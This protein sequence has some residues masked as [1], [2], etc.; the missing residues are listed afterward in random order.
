MDF[1]GLSPPADGRYCGAR[2]KRPSP[3]TGHRLPRSPRPRLRR[4]PLPGPI[5]RWL[6]L[7]AQRSHGTVGRLRGEIEYVFNIRISR[8]GLQGLIQSLKGGPASEPSSLP[9]EAPPSRVFPVRKPAPQGSGESPVQSWGDSPVQEAPDS[10]LEP[11]AQAGTSSGR[12]GSK[13][14]SPYREGHTGRPLGQ[15]ES[16]ATAADLLV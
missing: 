2:P 12:P 11:S 16:P 1:P 13:A 6:D 14:A 7:V 3:Q 8:S 9:K 5:W 15:G 4:T 10:A